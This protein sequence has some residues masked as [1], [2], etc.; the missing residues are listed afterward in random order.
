MGSGDNSD[1][2]SDNVA[3]VDL[4]AALRAVVGAAHVVSGDDVTDDFAHDESLAG[5][6]QPPAHVV[7]PASA[8]EVAA[9]VRL[10]GRHGV[11]VTARGSGSGMSGACV[12]DAGGIVLSFARMHAILD[13]DAGNQTAR[14]Q[15]GVTL[16]E[17]DEKLAPLGLTYPVSP[18][19]LSATV[20]GTVATN[21]GGMRAIKYGVTRQHVLGLRLV[22]ANGEITHTG[23]PVTKNS[24]GY[25]LTQLVIG[26]EGTLA[27]VTE[28]T[29]RLHPRLP[30]QRTVLA[31]FTGLDTVMAAVPR[32]I[33]SGLNPNIL[34]Y[35]D[36]W[37][38]AASIH[39]YDLAL[40]IP[41]EVRENAQAYLVVQLENAEADRLDEDVE[42]LGELLIEES[43]ATDAYVLDGA[44][45]HKLI[46][47]REN[48]FWT[49]KSV[50]ANEILD[51]VV[52]RMAMPEFFDT[53][54]KLATERGSGVSGCGHAGDGNVHMAVFQADPEIRHA[55]LHDIF[56]A[57][58]ALGGE[59]SGEHGLGRD[60]KA[61]FVALTDPVKL[62]LL[63]EIKHAFDP[64]GILNPG[65]SL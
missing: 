46:Q 15:A 37:T 38:M 28:A 51:M 61:H 29:L 47:A 20:G 56:A 5:A 7:S 48:A 31:P 11:P 26:S 58:I 2:S 10:A 52:P 14:V 60:K 24:S 50:G 36:I 9:V 59:I 8:D 44:A 41:D 16:S 12:P 53:I 49:A 43:R 23:G 64:A 27:L 54:R 57:A 32:I 42:A 13:V 19:E 55:L 34:E 6:P 4:A 30:Y 33:A 25:D 18:G 17:L 65:L 35:I 40:G 45:A 22:L 1:N 62:A 39:A 63:R 21:A 3:G